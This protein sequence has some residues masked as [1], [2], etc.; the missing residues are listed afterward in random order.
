MRT[1]LH[2]HKFIDS[3]DKPLISNE[4]FKR[5]VE[6]ARVLTELKYKYSLERRQAFIIEDLLNIDS[7]NR[8]MNYPELFK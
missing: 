8:R 1:T 7:V 5:L 6:A 2:N 3:E 4:N